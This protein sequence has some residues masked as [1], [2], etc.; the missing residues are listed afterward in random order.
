MGANVYRLL[1][2]EEPLK[3]SEA[4]I[5]AAYPI[6]QL[7]KQKFW[8]KFYADKESTEDKKSAA[9]KEY[10]SRFKDS[11]SDITD[12]F[13]SNIIYAFLIK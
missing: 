2:M 13:Y 7:A 6:G 12:I 8:D 9:M 10:I 11:T 1:K 3:K 4:T 5:S